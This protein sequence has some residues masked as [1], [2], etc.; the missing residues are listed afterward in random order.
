[1]H[2][3][4]LFF[5]LATLAVPIAAKNPDF[6]PNDCH[7]YGMILCDMRY[8]PRPRYILKCDRGYLADYF[9]CDWDEK[10]VMEK[11][12]QCVH[13]PDALMPWTWDN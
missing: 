11:G 8:P 6:T 7:G 12:A 13:D 3:Q 2:L 1:M 4:T 10:C 5:T 9:V